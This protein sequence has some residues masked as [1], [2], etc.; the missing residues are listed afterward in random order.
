MNLTTQNPDYQSTTLSNNGVSVIS[1]ISGGVI[2][3][4]SQM[5]RKVSPPVLVDEWYDV[6]IQNQRLFLA[7]A[8]HNQNAATGFNPI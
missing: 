8:K 3:N 1:R 7:I 2:V 4:G 5:I 6:N